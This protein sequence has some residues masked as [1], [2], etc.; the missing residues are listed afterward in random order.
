MKSR[1]NLAPCAANNC[2][3]FLFMSPIVL[4]P[5]GQK[6]SNPF[7]SVTLDVP[8]SIPDSSVVNP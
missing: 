1:I 3:L 5:V 2:T 6:L 4:N 8:D 7:S